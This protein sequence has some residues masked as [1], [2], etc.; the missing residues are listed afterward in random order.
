M[1]TRDRVQQLVRYVEQG[2]I[3]EAIDEFYAD[4]V[5]M[6]DNANPPVVGRVANRER[7]R[8]FFGG[9][10][11]HQH[12]ALS[13]TVDG[14]RAVIHWLFEFTGAD[15]RRYRMDQLAHQTWKNGRI[16]GERFYYDSASIAA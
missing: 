8:A 16:V 6:Q 7:E 15:G 4:D 10:D 13:V 3:V 1:S 5:S 14:D 9:I 11:V 12:R 2:R